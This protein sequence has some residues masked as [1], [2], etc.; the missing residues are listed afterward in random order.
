MRT[1][2]KKRKSRIIWIQ[3]ACISTIIY[4]IWR[5]AFT[6]PTNYGIFS[7]SA[8]IVLLLAEIA[9]AA[10]A[11]GNYRW[12]G[13]VKEIELPS[14]PDSWFPHIDILIA[15]HN[16]P[17]K[18]LFKTL[19]GCKLLKY[20]NKSKVHIYLCDD[21][22]RPEMK[23]LAKAMEVGYFG[24]ENN[25]DAKAG[26]LNHALSKT[27]SPL[28]VTFD[29][30][31]IP[32]STFLM[33][34]VPYF[35][36]PSIKKEEKGVW[37][38]SSQKKNKNNKN[39]NNKNKIGFIQ[40]P[41]SFYNPDLFQYNLYAEKKVPNEQD[42]FFKNVNVRRNRTNTPIYAGSN[43]VISREALEAVGGIRTKTVTEDFATGIAI[44]AEGYTCYA[45]SKTLAHGL[46]PTDIK[47]LI[48]QRQRW[49]RGCV[50]TLKNKE[51]LFGKLP[52]SGKLSYIQ[53]LLYWWTFTRRFIY[54]L[55]PILFT[56]FNI[57]LVDCIWWELILFWLPN[58]I[59]KAKAMKLIS[60][61]NRSQKWSNLVDTAIFPYLILPVF[62]ETI[63]I[64]EKQFAVTE[65]QK[66]LGHNSHIKYA[67]IHLILIA[68]SILGLFR[69]FN[70]MK[71]GTFIWQNFVGLYWLVLN[72]Y[73][74]EMAVKFLI[75]RSNER[76]EE[77]I[78]V[79]EKVELI[80]P[81]GKIEGLTEDISESG[82]CVVTEDNVLISDGQKLD[83]YINTKDYQIKLKGKIKH[84]S[85][86]GSKQ[87]YG[88]SFQQI[89]NK[90]KEIYYAIIY[91]R[92]NINTNHIINIC[93]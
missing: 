53:C 47:S 21:N 43:T 29:A 3:L 6:I 49:A 9:E 13:E 71:M 67:T 46:S 80:T 84:S 25:K 93:D 54:L 90:E 61:G 52:L 86:K 75:G 41:Q 32:V 18:L 23:R 17:E 16:E 79:Q 44:Q 45:I 58:Y 5:I 1:K 92:D 64:K 36:L 19:N 51:F 2:I 30:D 88:I 87:K 72:L 91:D 42:Y 82:M 31:M 26:N 63:G 69:C 34:T 83:I 55:S 76:Q 40:T 57:Y 50:H 38:K 37:K 8:G 77:R 10:Q 68:G 81:N 89:S 11:F 62:A 12:G 15:T 7:F 27:Y 39:K 20:P 35:F 73:Y 24:L 48:K 59:L 56:V 74:L 14:I 66:K 85:K 78:L 33:E 4:I 60:H 70:N 65:K 28:V 22:N